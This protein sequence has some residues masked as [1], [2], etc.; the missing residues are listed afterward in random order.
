MSWGQTLA[1]L[2]ET[3]SGKLKARIMGSLAWLPISIAYARDPVLKV[4]PHR[5]N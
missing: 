4:H 2:S 5:L 3:I 1:H